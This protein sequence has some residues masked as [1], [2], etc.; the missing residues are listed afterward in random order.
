MC[1]RTRSQPMQQ[2]QAEAEGPQQTRTVVI[3]GKGLAR[4]S[5]GAAGHAGLHASDR[6]GIGLV[7]RPVLP[8]AAVAEGAHRQVDDVRFVGSDLLIAEPQAF[9]DP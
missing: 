9:R 4:G 3:D 6:L 5:V 7:A 8:L 2:P 1:P